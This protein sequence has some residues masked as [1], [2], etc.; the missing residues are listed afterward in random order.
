MIVT[1]PI[2]V[3]LSTHHIVFTP[4]E[5][6]IVAGGPPDMAVTVTNLSQVFASF[7][8]ALHI[9]GQTPND[10][11]EWY[12]V[13]PNVGAKKPSGDHTTFYISLTKAPIPAY[14]T[15]IPAQLTVSSAE[16]SDVD[17]SQPLYIQILRPSKT[18]RVYLPLQDLQVTPGNRLRIPILVYNLNPT[19]RQINVRLQGLELDWLPDAFEQ[20]VWIEAGGSA[21]TE[22]WCAPA[23]IPKNLQQIRP[24]TVEATDSEGNSASIGNRLEILPFGYTEVTVVEAK[25]IVPH[26]S[27]WWSFERQQTARYTFLIQ[28]CSNVFQ[29]ILLQPGPSGLKSDDDVAPSQVTVAAAAAVEQT[30]TIKTHR[31]YVGWT[32]TRQIEVWPQLTYAD[33]AEAVANVNVKPAS[34]LLTLKLRPVIPGWLQ[35]LLLLLGGLG[36]GWLWLLSPRPL[37]RDPVNSVVLMSN[38]D[39]VASGSRDQTLRRWQVL[40]G[41]WLPDVRRLKFR[42]KIETDNHSFQSAIRVIEPLPAGNKQIAVGLENGGIQLWKVDPPEYIPSFLDGVRLDK[43]FDLAFTQNSRY[44]FSGHGS[45][46]VHQWDMERQTNLVKPLYLGVTISSLD[47]IERVSGGSWVAI[48]TQFNRLVLWDWQRSRAYDIRYTWPMEEDHAPA[49]PPVI[50]SNSYLTSLDVADGGTRMVTADSVG[51]ITLWNVN[52]LIQCAQT[53]T[54]RSP[55]ADETEKS[56]HELFIATCKEAKL[57]QWPQNFDGQAV[58][59][60]AM[61]AD[62]CYVASTGD[63]GHIDL[64]RI[65]NNNQLDHFKLARIPKRSLNSVDIH[66]TTNDGEHPN[67]NDIVL[68]AAD[69]AEHRVQL[70]RKALSPNPCQ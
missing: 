10:T 57:L 1:T 64:W 15:T 18:L 12:R 55:L 22:F 66:L 45:G 4:S 20:S 59:G 7:Q 35:L 13:E 53:S 44:L 69:T 9:E 65:N 33:S 17:V 6:E 52:T 28:N 11:G 62:G 30:L 48:A 31:P 14:G 38:G 41:A 27:L 46:R 67:P 37:H 68:V 19:P 70:F 26:K 3:E 32:Q 23:P 61:T 51:F 40:H 49:I 50:S 42:K 36:L 24:F 34:Q 43:V 54:Q 21:E 47:V 29:T 8:V 63:N 58:R 56:G 25:Q 39:T 5:E 60:V 16:L 2:K